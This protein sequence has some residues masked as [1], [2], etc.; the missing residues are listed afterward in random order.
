M[1]RVEAIC[2]GDAGCR[3]DSFCFVGTTLQLALSNL[4]FSILSNESL[5]INASMG[6]DDFDTGLLLLLSI[7]GADVGIE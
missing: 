1:R 3:P 4:L 7:L 2:S 6:T 5:L